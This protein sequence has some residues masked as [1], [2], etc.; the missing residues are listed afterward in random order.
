MSKSTP[1]L[2]RRTV[3][4]GLAAATVLPALPGFAN[5]GQAN[6][7]TGAASLQTICFGSCCHQDQAQPIWSSILAQR[8]DLFIFLGDN[9]Y[10]DTL[11]M[12]LMRQKYHQQAANFQPIRQACDVVAIW[13]DHD[14]GAD[15]VGA[16]YAAKEQSRDLF[17]EF[18][19]DSIEHNPRR[20]DD[21]IYQAWAYGPE[22]QRVQVILPDLRYQR[23]PV[24]EVGEA[25]QKERDRINLG[26]YRPNDT[27]SSMLS[28]AQWQWLEAQ[29]LQ[30]AKVRIIGSSI[31]YLA[32]YTGW[33]AWA[34][35]PGDRQRMMDLIKK[36][37]ANGVVFLSGDIHWAEL[38]RQTEG[39][40]YPLYDLT[41]SGLNQT[42]P[43]VSPNQY[44]MN[45]IH[46]SG[47]NF[48]TVKINWTLK[49]PLIE[50]MAS[51]VD[52]KVRIHHQ[53]PL[54][55]LQGQWSLTR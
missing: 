11:D 6:A 2:N 55:A 40:P 31:Q 8:P 9:I 14:Y 22:S 16:N 23:D 43:K 4:K 34:V 51:D 37:K 15:D 52:G 18:W 53:I 12:N 20:R 7:K 39:V 17:L 41:S 10:G 30:P 24:T 48:G 13:D 36:T 38:S 27:S 54:S 1:K 33:E 3:I 19:E 35:F 29:L 28:E 47:S 32:D 42:W 5:A 21:G 25:E 44:R 49:D 45:N 50:L 26:P 46:Y